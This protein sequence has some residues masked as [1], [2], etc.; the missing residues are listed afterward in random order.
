MNME[1]N[2]PTKIFSSVSPKMFK[3]MVEKYIFSIFA[4]EFF[5]VKLKNCKYNQKNVLLGQNTSKYCSQ[6]IVVHVL[7]NGIL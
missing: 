2:Y 1:Y 5:K 6:I 4:Y 7:A 3:F